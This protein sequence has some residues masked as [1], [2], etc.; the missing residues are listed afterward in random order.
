MAAPSR[1]IELKFLLDWP[2]A[3]RVLAALPAGEASVKNL[4][5]VYYDTADQALRRAGFG[6]RVRRSGETRIQT[7]K[8]AIGEDGGRD[9]WEWPVETD[10]PDISLLLDTPAPVTSD[11]VLE[12]QFTVRSRR[13]I[14]VFEEAGGE[15]ELVIDDAE[16]S[17]GDRKE[18]FLELELELKSGKAAALFALA[19]RLSRAAP[20]RLSAV[21]KAERG[22]ALA[23]GETRRRPKYE[24]PALDAGFS[25]EQAFRALGAACLGHLCANAESLRDQ[26]GPEGV[27]QLRVALRRLRAALTTFKPLLGEAERERVKQSLKWL[28]KEMDEARN[29]DVFIAD[30]WRPAARDHHDLPGM[31]EFGRALLAA[32]TR[33]YERVADAIGGRQ[34]RSVTLETAAWL[35]AGSWTRSRTTAAARHTPAGDFA[36]DAL[37]RRR[38]KIIEAGEDLAALDRETR[39]KVRIQ[40]KIL[41]YAAEDLAGLFPDHP[42]RTG[43]F[44]EAVKALQDGLGELNDLAFAEELGRKVALTAASP[45]AAFAVGRLT[46]ERARDEAALLKT[47]QAAFDAFADARPFWR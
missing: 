34:F 1:E 21:T 37:K 46:G 5:A 29:L 11:T 8:S 10:T 26:P 33:A 30:V 32:Q 41:R 27:H 9:E 19:R 40:A 36:A 38:K 35:Q 25:A 23:A 47:A 39:H 20:L 43:R 3:D 22:Y 14:R 16:V 15:I 12:P 18:A 31:A 2:A 7:L 28:A 6:L 17:A 24:V 4:E 13:T 42:K 45:D 44:I